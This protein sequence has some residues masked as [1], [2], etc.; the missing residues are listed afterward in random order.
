MEQY[1]AEELS[2]LFEG[3]AEIFAEKKDELCE[4][5]AKMG[6]GDLGLTMDKG[7]GALPGILKE[8]TEAGDVGKTLMK[9][10]MKLASTVP[11]TMGTLMGSGIMSGGKQLVGR[12]SLDGEGLGLFL[13]GFAEGIIKRGKCAEGDRTV[14]DAIAPA[15]RAAA[16]ETSLPA[17]SAAALKAAEEGVEATKAMLPK[18]GKAAVHIAKAEGRADQGATAGMLMIR[19]MNNYIQS[20]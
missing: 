18:F 7:Y 13:T 12:S 8:N 14:L 16:A 2:L 4:M 1:R 15:A 10:G 9:G 6:D 11:S 3:V 20:K 17:A 5:D 19:G